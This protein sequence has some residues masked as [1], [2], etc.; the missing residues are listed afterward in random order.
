MPQ[1]NTI[2][3]DCDNTLVLS[4]HLA[5][6]GCAE[7]VNLLIADKGLSLAPFDGAALQ[8]KYVGQNFRGMLSSL[9]REYGIPLS[10]EELESYVKREEDVVIGK[11]RASLEPA[12][13]VQPV[14]N[15]LAKSTY[16]L[17]VVSSSAL[18]RVDASLEKTGLAPY[19]GDRVYSAASSMPQPS[20][21]PDPAIY[22]FALAQ[23]GKKAQEAVAVEDSRSGATS[24]VRAGISTIGYLGAYP[25][26]EREHMGRVLREAGAVLNIDD[27]DQFEHAL[28]QINKA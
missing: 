18:R 17:A 26:E 2:L 25:P 14:L 24:A 13:G 12:E 20:T 22:Q 8:E 7:L 21:K 15:D 19:F 4:E 6:E 5:F 27:W 3:F 16:T 28:K 9:A 23:L 1:I 10:P 11:L